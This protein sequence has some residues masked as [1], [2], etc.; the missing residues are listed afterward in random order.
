MCLS[1]VQL[2]RAKADAIATAL[3]TRVARVVSVDESGGFPAPVRMHAQFSAKA[4]TPI[5]SG[6][7]ELQAQVS[8]KVELAD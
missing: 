3:G 6:N 4:E 7:L 2:A 8:M 5:E 1:F